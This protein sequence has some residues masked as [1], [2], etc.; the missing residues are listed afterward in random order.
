MQ[1]V[2]YLQRDER[3]GEVRSERVSV[4]DVVGNSDGQAVHNLQVRAVVGVPDAGKK[5]LADVLPR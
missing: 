5:V 2:V 4:E 1:Y 3:A